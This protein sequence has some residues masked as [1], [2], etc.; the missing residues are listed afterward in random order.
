MIEGSKT[1]KIFPVLAAASVIFLLYLSVRSP[2]LF[3]ESNLL[4][5]LVLVVAGFIASQYETHFWAIMMAVFFWAGSAFPLAGAMMLFRWVVLGLGAFLGLS[6]Y[7]RSSNRIRF[8]YLH[9]LGLFTVIAAFASAIISVNPIITVLKA[10]SLAALFVYA[11]FG[12]R[13]FWSTNPE[14]FVRKLLL[15]AEG[16]VYFLAICYAAGFEVWGSAN[17]LGLIMGCLCWP[18]LL[19]RF[20]LPPSRQASPRLFIA[21]LV[22]G[23]LLVLSLS[24]ASLTAASVASI[25]LL[26]GVKRY[27]TLLVGVSLFAV[28]LLST[29]L[30]AP[31]RFHDAS[32]TFVYKTGDRENVMGSRNK[33]WERSLRSF[34]EHPWL[35]LGFGA[36]D[37][38]TDQR[39][40]Y[41]TQGQLTRERGSSYLTMLE[42]TG[43]LGTLPCALLIL[44]LICEIWRVFLWLRRTGKANQPAV[45]AAA[46]ILAGFVNASFEDWMFAVGYYM[47]VIFW[48]LAFSLR[49]WMA[50]P[51][52]PEAHLVGE[53]ALGRAL[54]QLPRSSAPR[55]A[56][57]E[58]ERIR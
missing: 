57:Q 19:W 45:V 6:Y 11:S 44:A 58:L 50:C 23:A 20:I 14:P 43:L 7:A 55:Q 26:L 30:V 39:L 18:V 25:F 32:E 27:R 34:Q 12:A 51:V 40:T 13:A 8:N 35:G 36:A 4:A 38:S 17:S 2:Y 3:S 29:F 47:S 9:L 37:N 28:V 33:P 31:Q 48:V 53:R 46:I 15:M 41:A 21:L 56:P 1:I 5:L 52:W 22:C 54:R 49:D 24:R 10:L 16:L 42:T